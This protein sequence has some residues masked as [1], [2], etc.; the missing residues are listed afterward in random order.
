MAKVIAVI[1]QKGGV[2]KT[3][4]A[5]NLAYAFA[6][7]KIKTLLV[8][9]DPSANAS[10]GTISHYD[11]IEPI[12]VGDLLLERRADPNK[13]LLSACIHGKTHNY[14]SVLP[15][16]IKLAK[17]ARSM[18]NIPYKETLLSNHLKKM[19]N[20]FDYIIIDCLPTL[21]DL[22]I[23]AIYAADFFLIPVEYAK[24]ALDGMADLFEIIAEIK[25][26][27]SFDYKIL[28]NGYDGRT[29]VINTVV[30]KM[31]KPFIEKGVVFNTV[32]KKNEDINKA[33]A[34]NEPIFTYSPG[35]VS[36]EDYQ[37]LMK[38]LVNVQGN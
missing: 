27:E 4:T 31:L 36:C 18:M 25:L 24:D 28:R 21:T 20:N 10:R 3:A 37:N 17:V 30:D 2:G 7:Q 1:N 14:L 5:Y 34:N 32:I 11:D 16:N 33:K 22:N 12:T 13:A 23:N 35:S 9:L 6:E 19:E 15:S 8:D 26:D 29:K 38:E